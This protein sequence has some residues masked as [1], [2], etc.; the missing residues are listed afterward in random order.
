MAMKDAEPSVPEWKVYAA[1]RA[2]VMFGRWSIIPSD[3][4]I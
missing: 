3:D 2:V 1:H 4:N